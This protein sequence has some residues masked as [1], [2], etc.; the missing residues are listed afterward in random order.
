[1]GRL[2]C[3]R[4]CRVDVPG[5]VDAVEAALDQGTAAGEGVLSNG[6]TFTGPYTATTVSGN[7]WKIGPGVAPQ[8]TLYAYRV[9]GCA[10]S[11]DLVV[12][13]INKAV[14]DGVDVINMS[15]GAPFGRD[16]TADAIATNNAVRA[17][18]VVVTSAGNEGHNAY[19]AG[20]PG[21]AR[22]R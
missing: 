4:L 17:G 2:D 21:T 6:S 1:M 18:V 22:P 8:A 5:G 13:A 15:L 12:D 20:S 14:F 9:F 10:G 16:D 3:R 7:T 19:M 11:S